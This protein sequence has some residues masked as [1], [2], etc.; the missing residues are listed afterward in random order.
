M[1]IIVESENNNSK[2]EIDEI[3]EKVYYILKEKEENYDSDIH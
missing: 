2:D 3:V 1:V